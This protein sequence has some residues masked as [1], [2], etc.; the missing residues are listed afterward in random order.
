MSPL[1]RIG[2]ANAVGDKT[3]IFHGGISSR[4]SFGR[5]TDLAVIWLKENH[6]IESKQAGELR[7]MIQAML[8]FGFPDQNSNV[9]HLELAI[10]N[11]LLLIAL[12]FENFM[13][14]LE[15]HAEKALVQFWL[16]SEDSMLLKKILH[17]HDSVEMRFASRLNLIELRIVRPLN[18]DAVRHQAQSFVVMT[19]EE[20]GIESRHSEYEEMG[21]VDYQRWLSDVYHNQKKKEKSG[22][23]FR[24]EASLQREHE[25]SRTVFERD[26]KE[27]ENQLHQWVE[28]QFR[29]L[30]PDDPI[31][32]SE[33]QK[34]RVR[35][36]EEL[37]MRKEQALQRS[38][39]VNESIQENQ[40]KQ[41][42]PGSGNEENQVSLRN[43][44]GQST[45]SDQPMVRAFRDKAMQMFDMAKKLQVENS[46]LKRQLSQMKS[47]DRITEIDVD[48]SPNTGVNLQMEDLLKKV[49]RLNRA[50]ETEKQ[51]VKMLSDRV[52]VAEKEAQSSSP[53][54]EDLEAKVETTLKNSQQYKKETELVK[55]KLVQAEAEK[56]KIKNELL[57]AQAQIQTLNKRLAG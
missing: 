1:N 14:E 39:L 52:T 38:I 56:N 51:K 45:N 20:K 40:F 5:V 22:E 50:L 4:N 53:L 9:G 15:D 18:E 8:E 23:L 31:Q 43:L 49:E 41:R 17:H 34:Q 12:R 19:D 2:L 33:T 29:V 26:Q 36:Y 7:V 25:V 35:L 37:L 47:E 54:I 32:I 6:R 55:Q 28:E 44:S 57:K 13:I 16:N 30:Q 46:E 3:K 48:E 11:N 10:E 27:I 42:I 24:G 21:D